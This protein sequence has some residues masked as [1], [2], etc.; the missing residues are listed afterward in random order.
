MQRRAGALAHTLVL[1]LDHPL[2]R[3]TP[4]RILG[5]CLNLAVLRRTVTAKLA[6]G[7][8]PVAQSVPVD[9]TTTLL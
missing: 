1:L 5:F 6:V 8:S 3:S 9:F 2:F 7:V 4:V